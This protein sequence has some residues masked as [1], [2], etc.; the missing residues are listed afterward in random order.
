MDEVQDEVEKWKFTLIGNVLGAKP[1]QKQV[2]DFVQKSWN[3]GP[4]PLVQYFKKRWFSFKFDTEEA[5]NEVLRRGPWK[6]GSN[7]LILKQW[8]PYFSCIM[9]SVALVPT[10]VL[11]PDLDPYMWTDS[12]LSKMASKIGKP[13]FADLHTT[14]KA[15]LSFARVPVEVNISKDLP[16]HV[17]I[18]APFIGHSIQR[19]VYEWLPY[20]CHTCHKIGHNS[21]NCKRN[22]PPA[23]KNHDEKVVE[24]PT[25]PAK[26]VYK[27]IVKLRLSVVASSRRASRSNATC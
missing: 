4:L 11:F 2:S 26:K 21:A 20:Y 12:I 19:V 13:L 15:R 6:V 22:K 23:P 14:C 8:S 1:T 3:H 18:N 27:L 17:V 7:S 24:K 25:K 16:D 5:M 10:W 9:E